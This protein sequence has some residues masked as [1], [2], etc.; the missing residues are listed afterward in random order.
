MFAKKSAIVTGLLLSALVSMLAS[1]SDDHDNDNDAAARPEVE[2]RQGRLAGTYAGDL[3]VFK[4]IPY[5]APPVGERRWR[6]PAAAEAWQGVRDAS[7]F[8]PACVQPEV[9][10]TSLYRDPLPSMSED[11]LTLNVWAP[12]DTTD[13]PVIVWIH[14]G[15]LRIGGSAQPMFDGA[16]LAQAGAVI[17]SINYRLGVLGWLALAELS[18]ESAQGVSGNYGLLDQ[19]QALRWVRDNIDRFGGD[20]DN[21]TIMGE[22]AGAFSV[23]FLL[24]SPPARGLFQKAISESANTRSLPMLAT[25]ANGLPSAQQH[26]EAVMEEAGVNNLSELRALDA[27]QLV[28]IG[29]QAGFSPEGTID[30]WALPDQLVA[31]FDA[32]EQAR[33][34]LLAGFNEGEVRSQRALIAPPAADEA[35]Y[36][37]TITELYGDLAGD[38]LALYPASD[39]DYSTMATA[40]D[41]I[42]GWATERMVRKQTEV[43]VPA[44]LYRFDHCYPAARERDLCA[45]HA[46]ELPFVFGQVGEQA[47]LS[48]NWPR[49]DGEEQRELSEAMIDYWVSFAATGQ[50]AHAGA[51]QWN[52]YGTDENYLRFADQPIADTD[53]QPGMF[54]LQE[55]VVRRRRLA[56]QQ[57]FINVGLLANPVPDAQG[58]P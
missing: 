36:E 6:E 21:V 39:M 4:G 33:V 40:R 5:A 48:E 42:Y 8:G 13:L 34:P 11:C 52:Q 20:P 43:G 30:G 50:P 15:S 3:S 2:V 54:E 9:A 37:N 28:A 17:V 22:S 1:C 12:N 26:G 14:G 56:G 24:T 51:A 45:F 10:E 38:F 27:D 19:I 55:E 23:S 29:Q 44:Y 31:V 32:G 57:W 46:S 41:A 35:S 58:N 18:A 25:V 7:E 47:R 53:L 16:R 49:P